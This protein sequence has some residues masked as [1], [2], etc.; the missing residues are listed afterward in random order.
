MP[1]PAEN[2]VKTALLKAIKGLKEP[3]DLPGGFTEPELLAVEAEWTGFR[4][5]ATSTSAE[6]KCS[7]EEKYKEMMKEVTS[8]VTILYFHGGAYWLMDP[9]SH[10]NFIKK[11]AKLTG[12]RCFN[13]RYRLAPQ[14]PFPAALL[15][16]LVSYLSLLYPPAGSFHTAVDPKHIVFSGDS[17]GANMCLVLL[18]TLLEFQRQD[19]KIQW[20]GEARQVPVPAG[21]ALCSPWADLTG[22]SP[23]CTENSTYDYLP[24][25]GAKDQ[26]VHPP[27]PIWPANPPRKHMYAEDSVCNLV[28]CHFPPIFTILD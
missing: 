3:G 16:A 25:M 17:A 1:V 5:G 4:S 20:N 21:I 15:D 27:C 14:N 9:A 24:P 2:S 11:L 22:S 8:D 28:F 26:I 19:I 12:G 6:L 18:Q 23:S 7:E 10:R 13:V